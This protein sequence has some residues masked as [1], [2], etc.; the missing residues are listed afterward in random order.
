MKKYIIILTVALASFGCDDFLSPEKKQGLSADAFWQNSTHARQAVIAAYSALQAHDGSKWTFFEQMYIAATWKSDGILNAP[1]HYGQTI[2]NFTN[3]SDEPTFSAFWKSNY[4]GIAY[5]NQLIENIPD[6]AD[7]DDAEKAEI[8]AEAKFLRAIF[9]FNLLV[10]FENIPLITSTQKSSDEFL[11]TQATPSAVWTQIEQDLSDAK[12]GMPASRSGEDV[13]RATS[14]TASA[15]LGKAF[16]FQEKFPEAV[17]ELTDVVNNGPY[18]L[19]PNYAD[20]FNG[21]G[22]NGVESVFEIQW[23]ADRANNNDERHPF[24]FEVTPGAL[25]GW[26][27]FYPSDWLMTEMQADLTAGSTF[28]DRV[29]SSVFFNDPSSEMLDVYSGVST[30]YATVQA[31]LSHPKFFKK[32]TG[33]FDKTYYNGINVHMMRFADVLLMQAEA[34]NEASA[35]NTDA[36]IAI[37]NRVRS[38]SNAADIALGSMTQAQLRQQIRHHERPVELAMEYTI[39][40]FD[41]YRW[42]NGTAAPEPIS[43]VMA[44]H[45]KPFADNFV[46]GKHDVFPI[47]LEEMNKNESLNQNDGY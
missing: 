18:D 35:T 33:E 25:G 15:Y 22:E 32:Y 43:T 14:W 41:L 38:R 40:T 27:L 42:A 37:V 31:D 21:L 16:L 20:N 46:D 2:A 1:T 45:S 23:S 13:G 8:V 28:S 5:A 11:V 10:A 6:V 7:M 44:A 26:E 12:A 29:Y 34:M 36:A 24:N 9:H 17:T 30:P 3:G 39:R 19:L 4:T 47:P